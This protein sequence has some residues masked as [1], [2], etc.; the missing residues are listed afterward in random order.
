M[1]WRWGGAFILTQLVFGALTLRPGVPGWT[2][3]VTA[4]TFLIPLAFGYW[5]GLSEERAS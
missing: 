3:P 4:L 2:I 5:L 1:G